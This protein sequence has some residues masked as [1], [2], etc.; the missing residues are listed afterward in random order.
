LALFKPAR[1][2]AAPVKRCAD[3][4]APVGLVVRT[5]SM[6]AETRAAAP[7]A[8]ADRIRELVGESERV[9]ICSQG[10]VIPQTLA[11]LRPPN[12]PAGST[13]LTGKGSAWVLAF[14]GP[15]LVAA[16]PLPI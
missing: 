12:A 2:Y 8:V 14:S 16:D 10:G 3:T 4:V 13:F 5:D 11:A 7:R 9:V 6:F 1:V 15:D